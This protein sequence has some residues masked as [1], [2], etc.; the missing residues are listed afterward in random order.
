MKFKFTKSIFH[1]VVF[2]LAGLSH[3]VF[4]KK[5][6]FFKYVAD[7]IF[8]INIRSNKHLVI[9][10][11][12]PTFFLREHN[13]NTEPQM[14]KDTC[15]VFAK[16]LRRFCITLTGLSPLAACC[17]MNSISQE[18]KNTRLWQQRSLS[19]PMFPCFVF[20]RTTH[21]IYYEPC[22]LEQT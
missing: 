17:P 20:Q 6:V 11:E 1:A 12:N 4:N 19:F 2:S 22:V 10:K 21:G 9:C 3:D 13:S 18:N 5:H 15:H 16:L 7:K 8:F 14:L